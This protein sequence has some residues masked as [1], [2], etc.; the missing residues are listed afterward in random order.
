MPGIT[1]RFGFSTPEES[2]SL[3]HRLLSPMKHEAFYSSGTY[4]NSALGMVSGFVSGDSSRSPALV[5]N[6]ARQVGCYL[7]DEAFITG[8]ESGGSPS[9]GG[10]AADDCAATLVSLYAEQ[11]IAALE[12][13]NGCFCGLLVDLRRREVV[14]FNDRYG[15]N[16]I[17]VHEQSGGLF[18]GSEAKS[19]LVVLP[20]LRALDP[21]GLAEWF[22]CGCALENRT[23]FRGVSL[24]PPG[25]AW[26]FSAEGRLKRQTYF[27]ASTWEAQPL[28]RPDEFS[29][30]LQEVFPRVLNRYMTGNRPVA[31][32]LTGGLDG[33]MIMAWARPKRGELPCYTFNG[34]YRDCADVRIA[35]KVAAACGQP[36]AA[37]SVGAEF[38][39]Q[40]PRLAE[41]AVY[42]TDGAMDVTGAAELYV[43][44]LARQMAPV[45]L[46]GNYGS[47]ILRQHLA[48]KPRTLPS[49][50]FA[51]DF[52]PQ[53]TAA[54][55]AYTEAAAG[56]RLSFIAFKQVP[57]HHY[58]RLA[59]EQSQITVRSPFLDNELVA[60]A[61]QTPPDLTTSLELSLKLIVQGDA[62]MGRI[63]TD[64][65]ITYPPGRLVNR[66][67]RSLQEFLAKAEYAYDYGMPNW[68][69]R[70][71]NVFAPFRLEKLFLGRQKFCHFRTWYRRPLASYV[72][73]I[74]LDP[75]ASA[76]DYVNGAAVERLVADHIAGRSNHTIEIHK[77]L[78]LELLRRTLLDTPA[79]FPVPPLPVEAANRLSVT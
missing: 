45:R 25:S 5:W 78:S 40:F 54:A 22:S 74:L 37:I 2:S 29:D 67:Q 28:L 7:S 75:R 39:S 20:E 6:T 65:G 32:S 57:W 64:R 42:I 12:K 77:L 26:T 24:L 46:T 41:Q 62:R 33:R 3:L 56:N 71:D 18:F 30:R 10:H 68:L 15:L 11:G 43:N 55:R 17:Y 38:L 51:P 48:F 79:S 13:L 66:L 70:I 9:H 35:Q 44:R 23:L 47:E 21:R 49:E 73:Q 36:H 8:A 52:L 4:V 1:G 53:L 59:I 19:L 69:A 60:L 76:R 61:Y 72:K 31:M 58:A 16:R 27:Q 50:M 63:S 34:T 14:L